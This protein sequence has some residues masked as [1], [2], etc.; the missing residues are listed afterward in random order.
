MAGA[1]APA[2]VRGE[3]GEGSGYGA[4][5]VGEVIA[6]SGAWGCRRVESGARSLI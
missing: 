6:E 4:G 3:P 1:G 5:A 2:G